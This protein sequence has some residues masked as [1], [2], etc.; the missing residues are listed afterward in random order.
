MKN[1]DPT[2]PTVFGRIS[3][4]LFKLFRQYMIDKGHEQVS[5]AVKEI[6]TIYLTNYY[7]KN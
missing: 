4:D 3:R 1:H 5:P 7:K 2:Y 6:L